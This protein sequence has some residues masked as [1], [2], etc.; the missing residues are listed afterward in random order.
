MYD[1]TIF[2]NKKVYKKFHDELLSLRNNNKDRLEYFLNLDCFLS[3]LIYVYRMYVKNNEYFNI[4]NSKCKNIFCY[5]SGKPLLNFIR[6]TYTNVLFII[7]F[8]VAIYM[9]YI[10]SYGCFILLKWNQAYENSSS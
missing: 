7:I 2:Q 5:L 10:I 9:Y 4:D 6:N 1:E 8:S 3:G